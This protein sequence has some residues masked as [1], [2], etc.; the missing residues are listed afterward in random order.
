MKT[1]CIRTER[2]NEDKKIVTTEEVVL[3][4]SIKEAFNLAWAERDMSDEILAVYKRDDVTR[5][6]AQ[7]P[8]DPDDGF[9]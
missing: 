6:L 2:E 4:A 1:Y 9:Y 5:T 3:A 7:P 8:E